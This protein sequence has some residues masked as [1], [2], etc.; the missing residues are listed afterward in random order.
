MAREKNAVPKPSK[1]RERKPPLTRGSQSLPKVRKRTLLGATRGGAAT[2]C[3][4]A[5]R[6]ALR[7][8]KTKTFSRR[9]M[10][11]A[12]V[13]ARGVD[14]MSRRFTTIA[15]LLLMSL[16]LAGCTKCGWIWQ[17]WMPHSCHFDSPRG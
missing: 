15:A 7:S 14:H 9:A 10:R 13:P 12:K 17:D 11:C 3:V 2:E 1:I 5:D 8:F 16:A 4:H 6:S